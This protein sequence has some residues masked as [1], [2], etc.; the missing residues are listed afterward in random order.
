MSK[1]KP[2]VL[3][4]LS[5][6]PALAYWWLEETQ[7]LVIAL[8][9]G[10]SLAV[11]E[12]S[13]ERWLTGRL[14]TLSKLN[15]GILVMLGVC[16]MIAREGVWFKLQPT[17][18]GVIC[19]GWLS[20]NQARGKTMLLEMMRDMNR[21]WPFPGAWLRDFERHVIY[22]MFGFAALMAYWSIWGTTA[23]WAFWK[24]AGQYMS[25]GA[26]M[27]LEFWWFRHRLKTYRGEER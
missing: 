18:T 22:F 3:H 13:L 25:F 9:A 6:L 26:F 19:G 4:L 23:Q 27:A 8:S 15:T 24:T 20:L 17:F 14:H 5:F 11:L 2:Q 1:Q 10:V 21:P 7:P 12:L 16:A